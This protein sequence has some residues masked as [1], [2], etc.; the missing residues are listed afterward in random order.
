MKARGRG[1]WGKGF[2]IGTLFC[3]IF[4]ASIFT[5]QVPPIKNDPA[6]LAEIESKIDRKQIGGLKVALLNRRTADSSVVV[7]L[8]LR[9]GNEKA[10]MNRDVAGDFAGQLLMRG[11][12]TKRSREQIEQDLE[13]LNTKLDISGDVF[14]AWASIKTSRNHLPAVLKLVGEILR[15]PAYPKDEFDKLQSEVL[16]IVGDFRTS[17]Q[18][19][20]ARELGMKL[21]TEPR[22]HPNYSGSIEESL[23]R[24]GAVT[25]EQTKEFHKTLYGASNGEMTVIGDFDEPEIIR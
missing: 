12:T 21:N 5:Q 15:E 4:S 10:L 20:A 7:R 18:G 25:L 8:E 17:S 9:F 6:E 2:A 22:G 24:I 23:A 3:L 1:V 11:G 13:R 14:S 16:K 19:I